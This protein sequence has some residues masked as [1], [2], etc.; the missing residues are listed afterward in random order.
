MNGGVVRRWP[1]LA[2]VALAFVLRAMGAFD[3]ALPY[4][5]YGDEINNV[6]RSVN[7]YDGRGGFDLNPH[8]F[9]KPA[10]G[11]YLNFFTF[12]CRYLVGRHLL[13]EYQ[14]PADF[15]DDFLNYERG[16]IYVIARLLQ[17]FYGSLGVLL[18]WRIGRRLG[19]ERI[20]ILAA[21]FLCI[22]P[23]HVTFSQV[24]KNDALA[25]VFLCL[26]FLAILDVVERGRLRDH[27]LA[28]AWIGLGFATKYTPLAMMAVL[29]LAHMLRP[30]P[31][32]SRAIAPGTTALGLGVCVL[33]A[34]VGSPYNFLDPTWASTNLSQVLSHVGRMVFGAGEVDPNKYGIPYLIWYGL[35]ITLAESCFS[36]PLGL[37]A[38]AGLTI[39][40]R[41]RGRNRVLM[42][43]AWLG[44]FYF[45]FAVA[46]SQRIR[47]NH[48]MLVYPALA[49]A[50]AWGTERIAGRLAARWHLRPDRLLAG[51][52]LLVILPWPGSP[53]SGLVHRMLELRGKPAA[54]RAMEWVWANVP[55]GTTIVND[56]EVLILKPTVER[57]RWILHRIDLGVERA[58]RGI[59]TEREKAAQAAD[60]DREESERILRHHEAMLEEWLDQRKR[61]DFEA[62]AARR[63]GRPRYDVF[64]VEKPWQTE[65]GDTL[66]PYF[67]YNPL[68]E[69]FPLPLLD[70]R[71]IHL[72]ELDRLPPVERYRRTPETLKGL[73]PG[74]RLLHPLL[75]GRPVDYWI[76]SEETFDNYDK[77]KKRRE[78]PMWAEFFD[79]L[80]R[81]YD[82]V[83]IPA[84]S[85]NERWSI[86]IFDLRQRR[87]NG[88]TVRRL[89]RGP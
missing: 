58:R 36:W 13:G 2:V 10:L 75:D 29:G 16:P 34:F 74:N 5:F 27:L 25:S 76:A 9:N 51:I 64:V 66:A 83:E 4:S 12:G 20:G 7:F 82:A 78:F 11:Y 6:E 31:E 68:W 24:V 79:D 17:A 30:R 46:S 50:A 60:Y 26:S 22:C 40:A 67:G 1:I 48:L 52:V 54:L 69:V 23:A 49:I 73:Q 14:S 37:L 28:S 80:R 57:Y 35:R 32:G 85:S 21:V 15:G 3:V 43:A 42:L 86:R 89:D 41:G 59:A 39:G 55:A 88:A 45:L 33:A 47:P 53:G 18:T 44:V 77:P 81:H 38:M 61:F 65:D 19:G 84:G 87:E 70:R 63:Y 8:W 71:N 72:A 56:H 62:R